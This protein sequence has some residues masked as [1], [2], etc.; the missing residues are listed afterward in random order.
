MQL[1]KREVR[2][3]PRQDELKRSS[4]HQIC[5]SGRGLLQVSPDSSPGKH[6]LQ[7]CASQDDSHLQLE[8]LLGLQRC[9]YIW[10]WQ[11]AADT[12]DTTYSRHTLP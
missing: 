11:I 7:S 5:Q 12:L 4:I 8:A 2:G 1:Q 9:A 3:M 10:N 6:L